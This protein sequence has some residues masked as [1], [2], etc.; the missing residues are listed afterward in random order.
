MRRA[1]LVG[2]VLLAAFV[3]AYGYAL[4]RQ[5]RV[6]RQLLAQGDTALARGDTYEAIQ[7][8][9][10]AIGRKPDSMVGYLKRGAAHRSRGDLEAA[11]ADL[12]AASNLDPMSPRALELLGDVALMRDEY[13]RAVE[14][15]DASVALDD[16]SP[17]VL[18]KLGLARHLAGVDDADCEAV[19]HAVALDGRLAEAQYLLGVCLRARNR[20]ADAEQAFRRAMSLSPSLLPAREHLADLYGAQHRRLARIGEMEQ[21][22]AADDQPARRV[23]VAE[24]YAAAGQSLRAVRLLRRTL[25]IYP[26]YGG[27]Y[28][29]LGQVWLDASEQG[30]D[31]AALDAAIAA[32]ERAAALEPSGRVLTTLGNA[33]LAASDRSAA[34]R[35]FARAAEMLPIEPPALL[36]LAEA[37]ERDG[38][39][40]AARAA[41]IDYAALAA[42]A[43]RTAE[44]GQRI[45]DL[46]M[47]LD[48]PVAA[49]SWYGRAAE[50]G[51][52][53]TSLLIKLAEAHRQAGNVDAARAA[54]ALV[55]ERDPGHAAG[56]AIARQLP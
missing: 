1:L 5:E 49:A 11:A 35:A 55:F 12:E 14:H 23:S 44:I 8:F 20:L 41:L 52:A 16:R 36:Y 34:E 45:G 46:S 13:D 53:S 32:L 42:D 51:R 54:L 31:Q 28:L 17:R 38:R 39:F 21:L 2:V 48:E 50:S 47:R 22:L 27:A 56:R 10:E 3:V 6:F 29:A 15:F 26:D 33:Y 18:Y 40:S 43:D 7:A 37:A 30:R 24:A 9:G 19:T 25:E 4:T